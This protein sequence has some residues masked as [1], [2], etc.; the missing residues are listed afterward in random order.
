MKWTIEI[1]GLPDKKLN[2][3]RSGVAD[4]KLIAAK[5][6]NKNAMRLRRKHHSVTPKEPMFSRDSPCKVTITFVA[7]NYGGGNG[8]DLDNLLSSLKSTIDSLEP[9]VEKQFGR[10]VVLQQGIIANDSVRVIREYHVHYVIG[11]PE[12]TIIEIEGIDEPKT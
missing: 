9:D 1:D 5:R 8:H 7:K 11:K 12:R 2:P 6:Q 10:S 4:R 3:N